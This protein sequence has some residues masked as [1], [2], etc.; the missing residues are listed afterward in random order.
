MQ[1]GRYIIPQIHSYAVDTVLMAFVLK[2]LLPG[3]DP[4]LVLIFD[5]RGLEPGPDAAF[6]VYEL[7]RA[8]VELKV[9]LLGAFDDMEQDHLVLIVAQML[10]GCK[11]LIG[12]FPIFDHIAKDHYKGTPMHL[13]GYLVNGGRGS[14]VLLR[15]LMP[16]QVVET[17][18]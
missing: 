6:K 12:F 8:V 3:R 17:Q 18:H 14:G 10:Q 4:G 9:D 7:V 1:H 2:L 15:R 16:E 5:L 13:L 11:K